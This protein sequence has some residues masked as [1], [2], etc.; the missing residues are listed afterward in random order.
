MG[1]P[2][3]P[4]T[5]DSAHMTQTAPR[6]GERSKVS[7][8]RAH[9]EGSEVLSVSPHSRQCWGSQARPARGEGLSNVEVQVQ[10]GLSQAQGVAVFLFSVV[11][12][13][14]C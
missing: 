3:D 5:G 12:G 11:P 4:V 10:V 14:L 6:S 8:L 7:K 1:T 9:Q 2:E 13:A